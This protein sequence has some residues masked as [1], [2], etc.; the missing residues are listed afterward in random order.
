[1][2]ANQFLYLEKILKSQHANLNDL[3]KKLDNGEM[4]TLSRRLELL[5]F[6]GRADGAIM[7]LMATLPQPLVD[8]YAY[9]KDISVVLAEYALTLAL[10]GVEDLEEMCNDEGE[11]EKSRFKP[12]T[13]MSVTDPFGRPVPPAMA[14][15]RRRRRRR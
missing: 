14:G 8:K 7:A 15:I 10:E 12:D 4:L 11:E 13:D 3:K 6:A 2:D 5:A 1:M 9:L